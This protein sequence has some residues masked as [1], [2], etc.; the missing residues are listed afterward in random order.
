MNKFPMWLTRFALITVSAFFG[1]VFLYGTYLV[2]ADPVLLAVLLDVPL[3]PLVLLTAAWLAFVCFYIAHT[4]SATTRLILRPTRSPVFRRARL[5]VV[6]GS[7]VSQALQRLTPSGGP[8]PGRP[9]GRLPPLQ[10][11]SFIL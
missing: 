1:A 8:Y 4:L 7:G 5:P 11:L 10:S 3:L 9:A 2:L 6:T